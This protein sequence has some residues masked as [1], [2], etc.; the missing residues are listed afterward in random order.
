MR[1]LLPLVPLSRLSRVSDVCNFR[2][3]VVLNLRHLAQTTLDVY[4]FNDL[5][6]SR[7]AAS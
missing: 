6:N 5:F 4:P 3:T 7:E 1:Q 2:L